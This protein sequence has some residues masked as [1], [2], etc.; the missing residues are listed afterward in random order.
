MVVRAVD[1]GELTLDPVQRRSV[2]E[3]VIPGIPGL[4]Y[5]KVCFELL[6]MDKFI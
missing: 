2:H 5:R 3:P 4:W 1:C 6:V